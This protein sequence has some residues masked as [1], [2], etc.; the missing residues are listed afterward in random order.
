MA[1]TTMVNFRMETEL[2]RNMENV[3]R[4][5]G[6]SMTTAFHIFAVKVVREK[7]IPF[8]VNADPFYSASNMS[9]LALVIREIDSGEAK[10]SEHELIE[11]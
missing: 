10:L 7:R 1:E 3:C 9:H 8:E 2:K 6:I 4:E 11:V 5:M